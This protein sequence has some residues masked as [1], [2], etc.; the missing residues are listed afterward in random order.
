M[1][2]LEYEDKENVHAEWIKALGEDK[3]RELIKNST[4]NNILLRHI[5]FGNFSPEDRLNLLSV[6]NDD[7]SSVIDG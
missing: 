2:P 6:Y 3:V 4:Y 1:N 5:A 7:D